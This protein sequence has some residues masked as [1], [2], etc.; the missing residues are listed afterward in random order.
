VSA[1]P[2][3]ARV[4]R[5]SSEAP[6]SCTLVAMDSLVERRDASRSRWLRVLT[7]ALAML[8]AGPA[9]LAAPLPASMKVSLR[10]GK[11]HLTV[12]SVTVL[13]VDSFDEW[14]DLSA[15][16]DG[17]GSLLLRRAI[18]S[19]PLDDNDEPIRITSSQLAAR[20][21]NAQGMAL[22]L[23]KKYADAAT[24][25]EQAQR[26]APDVPVYA[27]NRLSALVMSDAVDRANELL[28]GGMG[29]EHGAWFAWRLAV[30]PELKK[31][32]TLAGAR[33]FRAD[34]PGKLTLKRL[35]AQ[36]AGGSPLGVAAVRTTDSRGGS[37]VSFVHLT[38]GVETLRLPVKTAAHKKVV[39]GLFA[40]MGFELAAKKLAT[41]DALGALTR[42]DDGDLKGAIEI[43]GRLVTV[44]RTG[45]CDV[46]E[47]DHHAAA[48][49]PAQAP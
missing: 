48:Q 45:G 17:D 33:R 35:S 37:F 20:I 47:Y 23:K 27:T 38:S 7:I 16:L 28:E 24:R 6:R 22:H 1:T 43:G 36:Q 44:R 21:A 8:V 9:A 42:E 19:M 14:E 41:G 46:T 12:D 29:S 30:D 2:A 39:D 3:G 31:L 4:P 18:C 13:L 32:R 26:D 15:E 49:A 11:P 25:F 34:R 5:R 40:T 10:K